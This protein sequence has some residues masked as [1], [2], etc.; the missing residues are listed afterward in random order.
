MRAKA[1]IGLE[2]LITFSVLTVG[3][4]AGTAGIA[5][6]Y[7]H[8]ERS[9]HDT[10]GMAFQELARQ[11]AEKVA[12]LL[13]KEVDWIQ[14]L[15]ALPEV[16][17]SVRAGSQPRL[18]DPPLRHWREQQAPYFRSMTVLDRHG[19]MTGGYTSEATRRHYSRQPWWPIIFDLR[20]HWVGDYRFDDD[21][22]G[23]LEIVAP[24][25]DRDD[26]AI[27]ALKVM[28]GASPWFGSAQSIIGKTGHVMLLSDTGMVLACPL[29]EP[30]LHRILVQEFPVAGQGA[31]YTVTGQSKT[32]EDTHGRAGGIIGIASVVLSNEMVQAQRWYVLVSQDP[33]ETY[34]PLRVLMWKLGGFWIAAVV[35]VAWLR[36]RLAKR[37]VRPINE[38]VK[39]VGLLGEA[40]LFSYSPARSTGIREIDRL[41][42]KFDELAER[43]QR[44]SRERQRHVAELEQ[45]N[46]ELRA[47]EAHYRTLWDHAV[48]AKILVD[49]TGTILDVN[50][51]AEVKLGA[52]VRAMIG[53]AV[54]VWFADTERERLGVL[55]Q[56]VFRTGH[57]Q[58]AGETKVM[59]TRGDGLTMDLDLTPVT[60]SP[61]VETV[62]LQLIDLT[63]RKTLEQQLLRTERLASLSQFA[64]MFAHDIRNPLAGIKKTL[65]W[66]LQ[67]PE[68]KVEPQRTWLEDLRFTADLLLGMIHDMLDVYQESYSGL[69]LSLS[70]V[71]V[72][73]L[74]EDVLHVFRSEAQARDV[75]FHL[76]RP[77]DGQIV[78]TVDSRRMQRVLINLVH[79]ALKYSPPRGVITLSI[80]AGSHE[81]SECAGLDCSDGRRT[82][83]ISVEDEGPGIEADDLPHIFD[84]FFRKKDGHDYRIGRGLGL[85]FC[86]LVV[87]AHHGVIRA[88]NRAGGGARFTV[89]LPL[90][91]DV[92]CLLRC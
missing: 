1:D 41:A 26:V 47:S 42:A 68:L 2:R 25:L 79:N 38:L 39:R 33:A 58:S 45:L 10:V 37:I 73:K 28:I 6:A 77:D 91:Q 64:S 5:Y 22:Q 83:Y 54:A 70:E 69:P 13:S 87:E 66:L 86:R 82:A 72:L 80:Q 85:H 20:Q 78:V 67:R 4:L 11:S 27:G 76:V 75:T 90:L 59:T 17:E 15:A 19:R 3:I 7:W 81:A 16:R 52:S 60:R 56:A 24:I 51:R 65:E 34:A 61:Q 53:Q 89:E 35:L 21:G 30:Q 12:L 44:T 32:V 18:N 63:E 9:L 14:R 71:S 50:R 49:S 40:G 31:P 48:D 84:M 43:L 46:G 74:A 29:L 92:P 57:E 23:Y 36:W 55:L 88:G 8:A 62:M